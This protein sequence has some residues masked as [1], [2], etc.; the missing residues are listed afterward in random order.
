ME[1]KQILNERTKKRLIQEQINYLVGLGV[2]L[3]L[4]EMTAYEENGY[5]DEAEEIR[6][7]IMNEQEQLR[8]I[9]LNLFV[10]FAEKNSVDIVDESKA[11]ESKN[12]DN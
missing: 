4:A 2:E 7:D 3:R 11:I 1:N 9:A 8:E 5:S 10:P 6:Q 12:P